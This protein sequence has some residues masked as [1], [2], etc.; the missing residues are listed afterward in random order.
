MCMYS[1]P[2]YI[3]PKHHHKLE[4]TS[5]HMRKK[6]RWYGAPFSNQLYVFLFQD[7]KCW[8]NSL[9]SWA[10]DHVAT[11]HLCW[12]NF[13]QTSICLCHVQT[14]AWSIS[15]D[16]Q[17]SGRNRQRLSINCSTLV[18]ILGL[19]DLNSSTFPRLQISLALFLLFSC[20]FHL[21]SCT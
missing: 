9:P 10:S 2:G 16:N 20:T 18:S 21:V 4:M 6:E 13:N 15:D 3:L 14:S 12:R 7:G 11:L 17:V 8:A 19:V 5:L 1:L